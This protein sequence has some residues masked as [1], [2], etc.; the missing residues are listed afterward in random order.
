MQ[1][2]VHF[3]AFDSFG[4]LLCGYGGSWL[5]RRWGDVTCKECLRKKSWIVLRA[6][7]Q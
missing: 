7:K 1:R 5:T 6:R 3:S 4:R 2:K